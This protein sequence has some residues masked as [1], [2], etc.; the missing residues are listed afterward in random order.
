MEKTEYI[1]KIK[2]TTT[3]DEATELGEQ[4]IVDK[5]LSYE[6]YKEILHLVTD[7]YKKEIFTRYFSKS[8]EN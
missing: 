4:A 5:D 7:T 8:L 3:L 2:A 6:E 1:A